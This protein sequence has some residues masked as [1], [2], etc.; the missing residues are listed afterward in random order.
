M[1]WFSSPPGRAIL[2]VLPAVASCGGDAVDVGSC[3]A[4]LR[5]PRYQIRRLLQRSRPAVPT[6]KPLYIPGKSV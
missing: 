1:V 2:A 3:G 4:I 6:P 5:E